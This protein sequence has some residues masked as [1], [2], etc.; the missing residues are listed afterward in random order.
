MGAM[1]SLEG[2]G[3]A[4]IGAALAKARTE[5]GL[6][7][8]EVEAATKIRLKYLRALEE[9]NWD[10]LPEPA[11]A[12]GFLRTYADLLGLDADALATEL[13]RRLEAEVVPGERYPLGEPVLR[14]RER[15]A[16]P[17]RGLRI[18]ALAAALLL[19]AGA[20]LALVG[21]IDDDD[22]GPAE[23]SPRDAPTERREPADARER[24]QR[25]SREPMVLQ[26]SLRDDVPVCLLG[27]AEQ[28]LID[29]QVLSAGSEEEFS[30]ERFE[31]RFPEGFERSQLRLELD[32]KRTRLEPSL[33]ATTFRIRAPEEIRSVRGGGGDCP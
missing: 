8:R 25:Q 7:L 22:S 16:A 3:P 29:N 9:E 31:L 30:A 23:G 13:R 6:D 20:G 28:P 19:L 12:V 27:E 18:A 11:Y 17:R 5:R 14:G 26:L 1:E 4:A 32:G 2:S 10:D 33:A 15:A 24:A 21:K